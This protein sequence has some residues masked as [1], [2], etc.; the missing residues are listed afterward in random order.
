MVSRLQY[1]E[2]SL[3]KVNVISG[4]QIMFGDFIRL[5]FHCY[6]KS[7]FRLQAKKK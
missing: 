3:I 5:L 6:L 4:N 2:A 7:F 1:I